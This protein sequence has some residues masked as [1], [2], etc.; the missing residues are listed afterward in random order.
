[1]EELNNKLIE[2]IT[3]QQIKLLTMEARRLN[4]FNKQFTNYGEVMI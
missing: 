3:F 2:E 4:T 1:M